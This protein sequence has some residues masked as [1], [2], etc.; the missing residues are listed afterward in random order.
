MKKF[1]TVILILTLLI[2]THGFASQLTPSAGMFYKDLIQQSIVDTIEDDTLPIRNVSEESDDEVRIF[3]NVTKGKKEYVLKEMKKRGVDFSIKHD[4]DEIIYGFS[5]TTYQKDIRKIEELAHVESV[6]IANRHNT[7]ISE[8]KK[9]INTGKVVDTEYSLYGDGMLIAILD[10]G[11]YVEHPNLTLPSNATPKYTQQEAELKLQEKGLPGRYYSPKVPIGY[12][13]ADKDNDIYLNLFGDM[14]DSHG[15]HVAG[16]SA[17]SGEFPDALQ[18]IAPHAQIMGLK[19]FGDLDHHNAYEDDIVAAI[20]YAIEMDADV[21]NMSI[22]EPSSFTDENAPEHMAI[23]KAVDKGIIVAVAAGN[24]GYS[25][26]SV[27]KP[28]AI[29]PDISTVEKPG[30]WKDAIQV[31]SVHN[32]SIIGPLKY[33]TTDGTVE[34]VVQFQEQSNET[35]HVPD[36]VE[37]LGSGVYDVV[38]VGDGQPEYYEGIDVR[39]KVVFAYRTGN[40]FYRDIQKTAE[41]NGAVALIILR[42]STHTENR[43]IKLVDPQI[44]VVCFR[45]DDGLRLLDEIHNKNKQIKMQFGNVKIANENAYKMAADSAYGLTPDLQM[46]PDVSA[47]GEKIWSLISRNKY[48]LMSG[49]SMATP[50][51]AGASILLSQYLQ[52]EKGMIK[53]RSLVE[54]V[55]VRLMNTALPVEDPDNINNTGV[56][57]L[58]YSP[59]RQGAGLINIDEAIRTNTLIFTT[60]NNGERVGSIALKQ[61]SKTTNFT[62]NIDHQLVD[63]V[64]YNVTS[65]ILTDGKAGQRL[66][67]ETNIVSNGKL[68]LNGTDITKSQHKITIG[69][70]ISQLQ[71]SLDVGSTPTEN[72]VEGFIVF[73]PVNSDEP[74]LSIP[75]VGFYGD[76]NKPRI[77]DPSE[78]H[79]SSFTGITGLYDP[80]F[81]KLFESSSNPIHLMKKQG[82]L[83]GFTQLGR[84]LYGSTYNEAQS[85]FS[86]NG[87]GNKDRVMPVYTLLRNAK[88]FRIEVQDVNG[89]LIKTIFYNMQFEDGSKRIDDYIDDEDLEEEYDDDED[90]EHDH[91]ATKESQYRSLKYGIAK[92]VTKY[93]RWYT[94]DAK[95]FSW[96]GT[97]EAGKVVAEGQ[98]FIV[99]KATIDFP[100]VQQQ[101]YKMPVKVDLTKPVVTDITIDAENKRVTWKCAD[102]DILGFGV[103]VNNKHMGSTDQLSMNVSSIKESDEVV[104]LAFDHAENYAI[105]SNVENADISGALF[106]GTTTSS[107][108]GKKGKPVEISGTTVIPV[109]WSMT[110]KNPVG[111]IVSTTEVNEL[112]TLFYYIWKPKANDINGKYTVILEATDAYNRI[113]TK[114]WTFNH[115]QYDVIY[116]NFDTYNEGRIVESNIFKRNELPMVVMASSKDI[117]T[118][119][120]YILKLISPT[121]KVTFIPVTSKTEDLLE[122]EYQFPQHSEIGKYTVELFTWDSLDSM[123]ILSKKMT[124]TVTVQ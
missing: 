65:I 115:K 31:A 107:Q 35:Q 14:M 90:E 118:S 98:Y 58:P 9:I 19:I 81:L 114:T 111:E 75:Y 91:D 92:N 55:K 83:W 1:I 79:A 34:E 61:I 120:Q 103:F 11:I 52:N 78:A 89:N 106:H 28:L 33:F 27:G 110:L 39:G 112:T 7:L 42:N 41:E 102:T 71:F 16:I 99:T 25:T 29:N 80:D 117:K 95:L 53:D 5:G 86:P 43:V 8:S 84:S 23:K 4:F 123:N 88:T 57:R 63:E 36:I 108:E 17:G 32:T 44:P 100:G 124:R 73:S 60:L 64:E 87:D 49:T 6:R 70:G 59:R 82:K 54:E 101:I 119:H 38:Y 20:L 47:P 69:S 85:G 45:K 10:S 21:I 37:T 18:G 76:W 74:V 24:G 22:G 56:L 12:D 2:P 67:M 96:D 3:V 15:T 68:M 104:I 40:Y 66:S 105:Y 121:G 62:V 48:E 46:K 93:G 13:F 30:I 97:D 94:R 122:W 50:H 109:K 77:I 72:F 116:L 113:T 51:V 26:M